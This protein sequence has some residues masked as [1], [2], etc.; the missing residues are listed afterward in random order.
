MFIML[1]NIE[2][3]ILGEETL[4]NIWSF[5]K[6]ASVSTLQSFPLYGIAIIDNGNDSPTHFPCLEISDV[7]HDSKK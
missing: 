3:G 5:A 2:Q 6:S 7:N 1:F 4:V